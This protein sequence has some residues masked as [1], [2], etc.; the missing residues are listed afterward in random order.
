MQ[1]A[2]QL[3]N[4]SIV[5]ALAAPSLSRTIHA[6]VPPNSNSNHSPHVTLTPDSPCPNPHTLFPSPSLM[7]TYHVDPSPS[8]N[9]VFVE[10]CSDD[11]DFD[12]EEVNFD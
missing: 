4:D 10:D 6:I 5:L 11:D 8:I 7:S 9:H 1:A 2:S 12:D 3:V